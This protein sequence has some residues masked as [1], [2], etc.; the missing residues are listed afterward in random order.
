MILKSILYLLCILTVLTIVNTAL[1]SVVLDHQMKTQK[2]ETM[3][4][5]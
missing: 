4:S 2:A 3:P 1:V 5:P